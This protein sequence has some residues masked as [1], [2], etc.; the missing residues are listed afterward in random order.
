MSIQA[1]LSEA[2]D[3]ASIAQYDLR[4]LV[5]AAVVEYVL[6]DQRARVVAFKSFPN[7]DRSLMPVFLEQTR[8]N[9]PI[10]R[11]EGFNSVYCLTPAPS[12][13]LLPDEYFQPETGEY[14][15]QQFCEYEKSFHS[16]RHN[17]VPDA[18]LYVSFALDVDLEDACRRVF[19]AN[20]IDHL[21]SELIRK[22]LRILK[23]SGLPLLCWVHQTYDS[24]T[25]LVFK[26]NKLVF[27]NHYPMY[28]AEDVV[29]FT[30]RANM[31]LQLAT[32]EVS[33]LVTGNSPHTKAVGSSLAGYFGGSLDI[34]P[35]FIANLP[36]ELPVAHCIHLL[37]SVVV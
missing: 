22:G 10:L 30:L 23:A 9:D 17:R 28:A 5:H 32:D 27:C 19:K 35:L 3:A 7:S 15:L 4:M 16:T 1:H 34:E 26:Q 20:E 33:C 25:Y 12:W 8:K 21:I 14:F 13:Q 24:F 11:G 36:D 31:A 18:G 37:P 29:Y 6:L 2:Y